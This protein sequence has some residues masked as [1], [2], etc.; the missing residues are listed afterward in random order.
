M[1][2]HFSLVLFFVTLFSIDEVLAAPVVAYDYDGSDSLSHVHDETNPTS[3]FTLK[4]SPSVRPKATLESATS[5]I[6]GVSGKPSPSPSSTLDPI[7]TTIPTTPAQIDEL[8]HNLNQSIADKDPDSKE[9]HRSGGEEYVVLFD[10]DQPAPPEVAQILGRIGLHADHPDITRVFRNSAFQGFAGRMKN[11]CIDALNGMAE[12]KYVEKSVQIKKISS[13]VRTNAPWGLQRISQQGQVRGDVS[14]M[15]FTYTYDAQGK[16]GKGVDIYV[17]DTGVNTDHLAFEGRAK[18]GFSFEGKSD[19]NA[20]SDQDG[21]GTHVAGTAAG[22][23]FG[24]ASGANIVGV[25]VLGAD[26]SGLSSDTIKGLDYIIQRHEQRI[27]DSDH[28]GSIASMSWGLDT[29]SQAVE[30]AINAAV[31]AG[32]HVSV[33]A[34][35]SGQD[36][37]LTSPSS[38]G[39]RGADGRGGKAI[40]VGSISSQDTVSSFSNTGSCVDVFAPGE[41]VVSSWINGDN[42]VNSLSGTS[43]ACPHVTGMMAYHMAQD[44]KLAK[45]PQAMKEFLIRSALPG[46][47]AGTSKTSSAP[48]LELINNGFRGRGVSPPQGSLAGATQPSHLRVRRSI[49]SKL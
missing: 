15:D 10:P 36:A 25:K 13:E 31:D 11:H 48:T 18:M 22:D 39:G 19:L 44:P 3:N 4:T 32:I 30:H 45:S 38:S 42:T 1:R 47:Q 17:V 43:M 7:S 41:D 28:V 34:G 14:K 20:G 37:C 21:H 40:S 35:N 23:L 9:S 49:S 2:S 8:L 27:K 29:R 6:S 5:T 33:A 24:V 26:G 46:G 12:V 16:L